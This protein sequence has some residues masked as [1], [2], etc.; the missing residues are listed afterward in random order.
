M[1]MKEPRSR[2]TTTSLSGVAKI[3]GDL[4]GQRL[5]AGGN[6]LGGDELVDGVGGFGHDGLRGEVPA[7]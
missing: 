5:D 1:K 2:P 4:G 3:L 7:F 6:S